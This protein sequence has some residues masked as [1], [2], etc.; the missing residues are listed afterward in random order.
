MRR[1]V[2]SAIESS[3]LCARA[4]KP[5]VLAINFISVT[6]YDTDLMKGDYVA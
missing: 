5:Q 1:N 3:P 4:A 2:M 6:G